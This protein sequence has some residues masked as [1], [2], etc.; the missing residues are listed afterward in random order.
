MPNAN[1]TPA[2]ASL[3]YLIQ[4]YDWEAVLARIRMHPNEIKLQDVRHGTALH[5][6]CSIGCAPNEVVRQILQHWPGAAAIKNIKHGGTPLHVQCGNSQGSVSKVR[7]LVTEFP[8]AASFINKQGMTPLHVACATNAMLPVLKILAKANSSVLRLQDENGCTP[9][10]VLWKTYARTM[11]GHSSIAV[12]CGSVVP[13]RS[14]IGP[15]EHPATRMRD[16]F[17]SRYAARWSEHIPEGHFRRFWQKMQHL[18]L[19]AYLCT[20]TEVDAE[21]QSDNRPKLAHAILSVK[22]CPH[23]FL[24]VA[25]RFNPDFACEFED[26]CFPLHLLVS[27]PPVSK[28]D[29]NLMKV[30]L[31]LNSY[32]AC[33]PDKHGRMPLSLAVENGWDWESISA[34]V[35]ANPDELGLRDIKTDLCPFMLAASNNSDNGLENSYRLLLERPE[36]VV[37]DK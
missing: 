2:G 4:K 28:D 5:A 24:S 30:M 17:S 12:A 7:L 27:N 11:H 9:I 16:H 15:S 31:R 22:G 18:T 26:G 19:E 35:S 10:G 23:S 37:C 21:L 3:H 8:G 14:D 32:A 29:V 1:A 36:L 6:V 33:V 20:G 34:I 13:T 25:L